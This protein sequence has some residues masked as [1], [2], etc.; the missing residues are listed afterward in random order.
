MKQ[1]SLPKS[2][3]LY[4][5]ESISNLFA[6]G[7]SFTLFPYRIVY[8]ISQLGESADPALMA[9]IEQ[10][11]QARCAMMAVAPKKRFRHAVDRNHV[12]RLTREAYRTQKLQLIDA[13]NDSDCALEVAFVYVDNKFISFDETHKLIGKAIVKLGRTVKGFKEQSV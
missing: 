8:R 10:G 11:K 6:N 7:R 3:R 5:R 2:E 9:S 13:L 1:F 4:L 12:K